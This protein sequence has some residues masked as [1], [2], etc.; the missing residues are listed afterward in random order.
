MSMNAKE[1]DAALMGEGDLVLKEAWRIKDELSC[2]YKGDL[3]RFF[4]E[5]R[6]REKTSGRVI[7]SFVGK[8]KRE[9]GQA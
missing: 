1:F 7:V 5:A 2:A 8:T 4:D 6:K 3:D 9:P